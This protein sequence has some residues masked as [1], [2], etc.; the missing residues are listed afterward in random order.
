MN[1]KRLTVPPD[2]ENLRFVCDEKGDFYLEKNLVPPVV[3]RKGTGLL[4]V[5]YGP[6]RIVHDG[7]PLAAE[8]S[9]HFAHPETMSFSPK[10]QVWYPIFVQED[11]PTEERTENLILLNVSS[12]G[13]TAFSFPVQTDEKGYQYGNEVFHG[14]YCVMQ[15]APNPFHSEQSVLQIYSNDLEQF[16]NYLFLRKVILPSALSGLSPYWNSQVSILTV[17]DG[18]MKSRNVME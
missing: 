6:L 11:F 8:I 3:S 5:Y 13:G 10:L 18:E 2:A 15:V 9:E 7:S 1:R 16:K 4:D 17:E 14:S 12:I